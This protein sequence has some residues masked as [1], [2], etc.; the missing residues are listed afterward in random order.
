M[1]TVVL[2]DVVVGVTLLLVHRV[3]LRVISDGSHCRSGQISGSRQM[4]RVRQPVA[5][6]KMCPGQAHF[7]GVTVHEINKG[8]LATGN[9]LGD[10]HCRV[11]ARGNHY[12]AL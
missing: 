6:L 8:S 7:L 12:A 11:I 5:I 2:G 3:S 1:I 4:I 9:V 10:G